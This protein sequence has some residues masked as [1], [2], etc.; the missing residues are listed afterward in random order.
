MNFK[1]MGRFIAQILFLE[2]VFMIPALLISLFDQSYKAAWSF[3]ASMA[4]TAA[5]AGLLLLICH[6][7]KNGFYA[8]EGLPS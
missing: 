2:A 3:L 4:L 6:K 5:L 7:K 8:R 1:M